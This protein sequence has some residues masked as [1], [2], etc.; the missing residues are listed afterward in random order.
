M[1]M[2]KLHYAAISYQNVKIDDPFWSSRIEFMAY[3]VIPYQWN[4][5]NDNIPGAEPSRAVENFRIAAGKSSGE[6]HGMF[7]QYS[8][9][10]KWLEAAS[11]SLYYYSNAELE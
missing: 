11:Y 8:D 3:E 10:A 6:F 1:T 2:N 5:L 9:V 4:V 7:F